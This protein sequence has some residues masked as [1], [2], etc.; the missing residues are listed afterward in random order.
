MKRVSFFFLLRDVRIGCHRCKELDNGAINL[1]CM[2]SI[3]ASHEAYS[4]LRCSPFREEQTRDILS[5]H[6]QLQLRAGDV[7][8]MHSDLAHAGA[9]NRSDTIREMLYF[10]IRPVHGKVSTVEYVYTV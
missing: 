8:V 5:G 2:Q 10:R 9:P 3:L 6:V 1:E 4:D 7:V